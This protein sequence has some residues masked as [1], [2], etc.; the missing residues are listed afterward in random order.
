MACST[1]PAV[2]ALGPA[3]EPA[4]AALGVDDGVMSQEGRSPIVQWL[5]S[6]DL[7]PAIAEAI[8]P[9]CGADPSAQPGELRELRMVEAALTKAFVVERLAGRITHAACISAAKRA[10]DAPFSTDG[11]KEL[12]AKKLVEE[13][14]KR[15]LKAMPPPAKS[16]AGLTSLPN[17]G[18]GP[19]VF[20]GAQLLYSSGGEG[21]V[22]R[23][24]PC[25]WG[26]SK[27]QFALFVDQVR[28]AQQLGHLTNSTPADAEPYP[29]DKFDSPL[30]GPSMVHTH[31]LSPHAPLHAPLSTRLSMNLS[32]HLSMNLST[33]AHAPWRAH[34][35]SE[36]GSL[37][38][39]KGPLRDP[40]STMPVQVCTPLVHSSRVPYTPP[41]PLPRTA[42]PCVASLYIP[43]CPS[44]SQQPHRAYL[45]SF[46]IPLRPSSSQ[47]PHRTRLSL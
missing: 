18:A 46:S 37:P 25:M 33:H 4:P 31:L 42:S 1:Q 8:G 14:I 28:M 20:T 6:I 10:A 15:Q 47:Q 40:T 26:V 45:C 2:G 41:P 16:A 13:A 27:A 12:P 38:F 29:Q 23:L 32:T 24:P 44:S 39:T 22:G 34:T 43:L 17:A 5:E 19:E 7:L 9:L 36:Q 30:V 11:I 21:S 3:A 35:R